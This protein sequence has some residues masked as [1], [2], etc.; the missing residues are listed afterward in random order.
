M[1]EMYFKPLTEEDRKQN[2]YLDKINREPWPLIFLV[3]IGLV[4]VFT[5]LVL[6]GTF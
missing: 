1:R 6:M 5:M 3:L 4:S 2:E